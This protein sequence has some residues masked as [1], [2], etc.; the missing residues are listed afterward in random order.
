MKRWLRVLPLVI[1]LGLLGLALS[2]S[3]RLAAEAI[4]LLADVWLIGRAPADDAP[5]TAQLHVYAGP[6][7]R[8]RHADLYCD[9][10][11]TPDGRLL[12]VHGLVDTGK[13][14]RRLR[15]LGEALAGH[16]FLVMVADFPG[17][18]A[19]KAG[20]Q[21]IDEVEAALRALNRIDACD[22]SGSSRALPTGVVG[23]SY[24]S[25]PVLL[26]LARTPGQARY[27]VLFGGYHDLAAVILFLTTGHHRHGGLDYDGE[28]LPTGRWSLL[29]ANATAIADAGDRATLVSLAR[30]RRSDPDAGIDDLIATLGPGAVAALDLMANTD[31][32]R[33]EPLFE[34]TD[35]GL[36]SM[37]AALSPARMI[38]S[39]LDLDL[40]LLHAR[41]DVI[42]PYT[43]SLELADMI[44]VRGEKRLTLLGGFR[45]ARPVDE[46]E[47]PWWS[48]ALRHPGDSLGLLGTLQAILRHRN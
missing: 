40:F 14:D 46:G 8:E 43:Q 11:G 47:R 1:L 18:R 28:F 12:L 27:A 13:D 32:A 22:G 5:F 9:D 20:R 42:V 41:G 21:D 23:F 10:A 6:G 44:A 26:A 45:H 34:R 25:G 33:F 7:G 19:L 31:P 2:P 39:R 30:R 3:G 35:P 4:T 24:S 16:R 36:R 48:T 37:I 38:H 15:N 29:E 17:M